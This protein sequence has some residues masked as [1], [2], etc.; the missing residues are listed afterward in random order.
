MAATRDRIR[1]ESEIVEREVRVLAPDT[2]CKIEPP[3]ACRVQMM[4]H[5][6]SILTMG[7]DESTYWCRPG[8]L[9]KCARYRT[10]AEG[11][12]EASAG[13]KISSERD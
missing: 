10:L 6:H 12:R 5:Q 2:L 11:A 1:L 4:V 7:G 8:R 3:Q 9:R 13:R